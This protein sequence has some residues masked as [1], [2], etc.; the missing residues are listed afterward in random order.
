MP[1]QPDVHHDD[2]RIE[3]LDRLER[4]FAGLHGA[5]QLDLVASVEEQGE[6][7]AHNRM[8]VNT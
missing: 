3:L 1:G 6:A 4:L 2:L 5:D 8:V 7:L